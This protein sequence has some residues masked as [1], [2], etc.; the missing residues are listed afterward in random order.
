MG[1]CN[2]SDDGSVWTVKWSRIIEDEQFIK[3][4]KS[5]LENKKCPS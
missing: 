4:L 5:K 2:N 1:I 3:N